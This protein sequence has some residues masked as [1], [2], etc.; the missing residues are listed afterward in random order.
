MSSFYT[1]D[2]EALKYISG[3]QKLNSCRAKWAEFLQEFTFVIKHKEGV[4]N[5][6]PDVLSRMGMLLYTM[7]TTVPGFESFRELYTEDTYFP[8]LWKMCNSSGQQLLQLLM[9]FSLR[10]T[11]Y[12]CLTIPF[13]NALYLS[14]MMKDASALIRPFKLVTTQYVWQHLKHDVSRFVKHCRKCQVAKG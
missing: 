9:V 2:H 1:L 5:K 13:K 8:L 7:H 6:V 4:Q 14:C 12:V 11:N 3:Q 10:E